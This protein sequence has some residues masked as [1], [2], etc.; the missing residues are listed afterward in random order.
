VDLGSDEDTADIATEYA[1]LLDLR[2]E[3]NDAEA[4]VDMHLRELGYGA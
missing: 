2:A 4:V 1:K 3:R